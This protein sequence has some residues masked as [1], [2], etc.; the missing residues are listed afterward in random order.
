VEKEQH[1]K[2]DFQFDISEKTVILP[3]IF[4][5][6]PE[7]RSGM[8]TKLGSRNHTSDGMNLSY[9]VGDNP[10][11]VEKNRTAFFSHFGIS[12]NELAIPQQSHSENVRKVD[13]PGEYENCDALV[14]NS[15]NVALVVTVAD[16]VPILLFD[17]IQKAI[18][19]VHAGW[20]G[21]A[22][23][24]VKRAIQKLQEEFKTNTKNILAFIGPSAGVCCYEVR[25]DVAVKFKNKIVP[26]TKKKIF[27]DLKKE[28]AYQ[29]KQ[30]GVPAGNI[31]I[32]KHCTI[33]ER[34]LFHSY[35]R[36]GK[37]AGRMM[38]GICMEL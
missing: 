5:G 38:A 8:S 23:V 27:V 30:L 34:Q 10:A 32:S 11:I 17:P 16:C 33:C 29:L 35:R 3:K 36:E 37:S 24:I 13:T 7:V 19:A 15:S 26:Y 21:T 22:N 12:T 20:R 2:S 31:E 4:S 1:L 14:T 9:N 28:N 6:Y 25:E 18:G